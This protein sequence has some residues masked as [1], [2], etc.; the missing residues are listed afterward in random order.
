MKDKI[1]VCDKCLRAS[2]FQGEFYCDEYQEAGTIMKTADELIMLDLEHWSH[3]VDPK[4]LLMGH[5]K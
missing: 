4:N 2:C 5:P 3:W 1:E